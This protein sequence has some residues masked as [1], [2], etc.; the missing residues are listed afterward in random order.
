M[1]KGGAGMIDSYEIEI[2]RPLR[3]RRGDST[4]I[5]VATDDQGKEIF[6]DRADLNSKEPELRSPTASLV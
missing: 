6:R 1:G 5:G 2:Q 3:P 4:L